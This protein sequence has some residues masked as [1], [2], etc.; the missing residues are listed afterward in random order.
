[1]NTLLVIAGPTAVG[2]TALAVELAQV[3][4]T[5]IVSCDSRQFYSELRIGVARP[6]EA[7]LAAARHHFI[8]CRTVEQPYNVFSYEQEALALIE[9][10]FKRHEVVVAVGGSGL[11][12]DA[13]CQGVALLPDPAPELRERLQALPLEEKQ[14][15]LQELDPE[16]Y[17]QVDRR[18]PVRLQRAL[19]VCLTAGRPYSEVVRQSAPPRPFRIQKV[20]LD[21]DRDTL[22]QRIGLRADRMI[23]EGLIEEC[24]GLLPHRHLQALNTVG[25]KE[26]FAYLDGRLLLEQALAD[27]KTHTWQYAK[28]QLTWLHRYEDVLWIERKNFL[29]PVQLI[30]Q[31]L[32]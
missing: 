6:T 5:E 28:K 26:I 12:I 8:A 24:R 19:E 4:G 16:C 18:N 7:E 1:M 32:Y 30:Q 31:T 2:K 20:A 27:I 25:Y 9:R 22:R 17:A 10:L 23:E 29:D 15:R 3:L 14:R 21:A 13:L 11:Y